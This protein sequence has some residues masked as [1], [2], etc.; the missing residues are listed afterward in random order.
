MPFTLV[1]VNTATGA[2]YPW[3][4]PV[5]CPTPAA[6]VPPPPPPPSPQQVVEQV[7]FPQPAL[8]LDPAGIGVAQLPTWF[9]LRNDGAGDVFTVGPVGVG[10]YTVLLTARPVAYYWSFGDGSTAVSRTAGGP[11]SA[12]SASVVHTY[13][14]KGVYT[15][16]VS[17][18]WAGSYTFA[19]HGLRQTASLGPVR[20]G[21][22][23]RSY[24][25]QEIR[26]VLTREGPA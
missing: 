4:A 7:A 1:P 24:T 13:R 11:G 23:Y 16:G 18:A 25:V 14:R 5:S 22:A 20:Q 3:V 19:G 17:V 26:S 9:W 8:A 2:Y 21:E 15:V 12:A 6:P 10:G